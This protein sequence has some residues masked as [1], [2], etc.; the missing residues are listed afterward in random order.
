[1][2]NSLQPT[3]RSSTP[4]ARSPIPSTSSPHRIDQAPR[5]KKLRKTLLALAVCILT[6]VLFCFL[7]VALG[8]WILIASRR[9]LIPLYGAVPTWLFGMW[10]SYFL[11]RRIQ[12][13][14]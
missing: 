11:W 2:C 7:G 12:R 5:R 1:L 13:R 8:N 14:P 3:P 10:L 4:T 9:N 6:L